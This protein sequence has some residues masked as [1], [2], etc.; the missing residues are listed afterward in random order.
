[1]CVA[2]WIFC[3]KGSAPSSINECLL[4]LPI[5]SKK[6]CPI[7]SYSLNCHFP[8]VPPSITHHVLTARWRYL[9]RS[10]QKRWRA[11]LVDVAHMAQTVHTTQTAL[12]T[13]TALSV[14][15]VTVIFARWS[16]LHSSIAHILLQ[17]LW[18][19]PTT[20]RRKHWSTSWHNGWSY[21]GYIFIMKSYTR[22]TI[23]RKWKRQGKSLF[24]VQSSIQGV[25]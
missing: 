19:N 7:A 21:T 13:D 24:D 4:N 18:G 23:K 12:T 9:A 10:L 17:A 2:V 22:Y 14:Q 15:L 8:T 5:P 3:T 6:H 1:M 11:N 25:T 20:R 16:K